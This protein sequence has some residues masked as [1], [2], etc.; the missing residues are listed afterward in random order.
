MGQG[1]IHSLACYISSSICL[2]ILCFVS[3]SLF[4]VY[5]AFVRYAFVN[6]IELLA[7]T[8][9]LILL[10]PTSLMK[11]QRSMDPFVE[12]M[13][14]FLALVS[15]FGS[16]SGE[17]Y[18]VLH[19]CFMTP[20]SAG[21]LIGDPTNTGLTGLFFRTYCFVLSQY[22]WRSASKKVNLGNLSHGL[23]DQ[24]GKMTTGLPFI[25]VQNY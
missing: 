24:F 23:S 19:L 1:Q 9:S 20:P 18:L 6:K 11:A 22:F 21:G 10:M 13:S 3:C 7:S 2:Q 4:I 12:W 8:R 5:R 14:G 17:S 25:S 16:S 15:F